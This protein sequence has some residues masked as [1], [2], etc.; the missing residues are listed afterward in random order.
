VLEHDRVADRQ[1]GSRE[2]GH[3]VG[4]VVPRH[5]PEQHT[6]RRR[7]HEGPPVAA[8]QRDL[9]VGQLRRRDLRQVAVDVGAEVDLTQR[10]LERL[11]HLAH[12][13]RGELL[14]AFLVEVAHAGDQRGPVLDG[15]ARP[16]LL[17]GVRRGER[18]LELLRGGERDRG[19]GL[20]GGRVDD[21]VVGHCFSS[22]GPC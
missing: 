19:P 15:R 10:L 20:A 17:R 5:D 16:L 11:A 1:V 22:V 14:A 13:D 2:P 6:D 18:L 4:R 21:D 12:D 7:P 9:A 8:A 3:L